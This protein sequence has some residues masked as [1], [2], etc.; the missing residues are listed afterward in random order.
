MTDDLPFLDGHESPA[1]ANGAKGAKPCRRH[2]WGKW[3]HPFI[4]DMSDTAAREIGLPELIR[5]VRCGRPKDAT[6]SRRGRTN[7]SRGKRAEL[8]VARS[9]PGA[10]KMGP[11]GLSWDV[12]VGT[13][14]RLQVKKLAHRPG[15]AEIARLIERI[16]DT[17]DR[18]RG[19]VWVEAA[20]RGK[21]GQRIVWFPAHEFSLWH[22]VPGSATIPPGLVSMSLDDWASEFVGPGAA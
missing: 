21:R 3:T 15:P 9:I 18:L 17:G 22:G 20:G 5:C 14:A 7:A 8:D 11:L 2:D 19:F 13:Y 16:P 4:G 1:T 12:E 10:R 6:A